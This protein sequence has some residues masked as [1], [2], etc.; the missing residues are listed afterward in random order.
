[1]LVDE[2]GG[3]RR[4]GALATA[5]IALACALV[6]PPVASAELFVVDSTADEADA[7]SSDAACLTTGGKCTLRAA[8]E[9]SNNPAGEFDEIVFDEDVFDGQAASSTID[10]GTG[11]PAI[12]EPGRVNGHVCNTAAGVLGPCVGIDGP[13][14]TKPALIVENTSEVE[15]E[16]LAVTGAQT[17]IE[18]IGS[19][20]K[21]FGSWFGVKL[22][23]SADGNATGVFLDPGSSKARIGGEGAGAGNLFANNAVDGLDILGADNIRVLG[24]YF[25]VK[26]DGA[27]QAA[28]GKDIE[29]TSVSNG[30]SVATGTAIGT[31]VSSG[32]VATPECDRGCNVISGAASNGIDLEGDGGTESPAIA[33]TIA[34]NYIG[35]NA[36]GTA[37]VPNASTNVL[38]GKAAQ[39]VIGGPKAG[40]TN[41]I[42]GG[43]VGVLAGPAAAGLA[44][45]NNLI[46]VDATG[47][48]VLSPPD[49]GI[50]INSEE[51]PSA[52]VE[53]AIVDNEI[54]MEGGVAIAQK[55][56]GAR[57]TGN[58][59]SG[60]ETGI[61]TDGSTEEKWGNLIEGN[62]IESPGAN[63]I[64][65]ENG[66]NEILG[67]EISGAG[68]AGIRIHGI[69]SFV[70]T[71]N[72]VGGD[73]ATDENVIT[74]SG[75]AA[76]EISNVEATENEVAR[77][78]GTANNGLFIDL[79]AVGAE[80][81][82]PNNGIEP[83]GIS[84]PIQ[85]SASGSADPGA[86]VRVFL[87][88]SDAAGEL[89]SFLGEATADASG[90]WKVTYG[91]VIPVGT[92][93]AATQ[94]SKEG[95]TSELATVTTLFGTGSADSGGGGGNAGD[96]AGTA[97]DTR[98][99][100]G[101]TK[102]RTKIVKT[103]KKRS[104]SN[105]AR[106]EFKSDE[107]GSIFLC[108]LDKKPFDLCKSPKKYED[109]QPGRHVFQVRAID[110]AGHADASPAMMKFTLLG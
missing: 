21:V 53:A 2:A 67:N 85:A 102:P 94:T 81:K 26:P 98:R 49:G 84:A 108:K 99:S 40:E 60:A 96:G 55:G 44:I 35:L 33:T 70:V 9:E 69:F 57:I 5:L 45:R 15:I 22:D 97:G 95:G 82:G 8:I 103:P 50:V 92:R 23:G 24:N 62:L 58:R 6:V 107:L 29:V 83:P 74:G 46:G 41:R 18:V 68:G 14:A 87:K 90:N 52:A 79:V 100:L 77:N 1:M 32:A 101:P 7:A 16:G 110:P 66:L 59:I 51:V 48:E 91:S 11:L 19:E 78:R 71:E 76:I 72:L 39:T 75:G 88:Q 13:N 3:R 12:V 17:G 61:K 64:L 63:G 38:V 80:P 56:L 106:F 105:T 42:N 10:L 20:F 86:T 4:G 104:R 36:N 47:T 31:R 43:S 109:L 89:E 25:G 54:G 93:V 73:V 34:G 30:G 28:N 37:A 65:V 27:T